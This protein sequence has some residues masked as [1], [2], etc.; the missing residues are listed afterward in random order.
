M[1]KYL[2]TA[3]YVGDGVRGLMADGG[4]KRVEAV[5]A[6][7]GSLG[8]TVESFYFA[9]GD[10]D[11]YVIVDLPDNVSAAAGS[12]AASASGAVTSNITVLLSPEEV[13]EAAAKSPSYRPPGG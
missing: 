3:N 1:P 8:G 13:D 12:L 10:T 5:T 7:I 11:A 9:F 6:L 2:I 4:S